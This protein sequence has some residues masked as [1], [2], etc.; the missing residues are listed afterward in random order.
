MILYLLAC[1][2]AMDLGRATTLDPGDWRWSAGSE[3]AV[4]RA[5]LRDDTAVPLP[6]IQFETGAHTGVTE[7]LEVGGRIWGF[8]LQDYL[9]SAGAAVDTKVQL[10]R[11]TRRGIPHVATGLSLGLQVPELGGTPW[12]VTSATVPL[13]VGFD[14]QKANQ[15]VIS[16]RASAHLLTAEGQ[17]ALFTPGVGVGAG[18]IIRMGKAELAPELVWTYVPVGWDGTVHAPERTGAHSFQMG[19]GFS[20]L[21]ED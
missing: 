10:H 3:I 17:R 19:V 20:W 8:G 4:L 14:V 1:G 18:W 11:S 15:I 9:R 2:A 7:R 13:F 5:D 16:P 21:M 12:F 6:W